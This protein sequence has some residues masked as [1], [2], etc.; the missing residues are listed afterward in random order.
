MSIN[1]KPAFAAAVAALALVGCK[2]TEN[3][4]N[5]YVASID[6]SDCYAAFEDLGNL[7][8][9]VTLPEDPEERQQMIATILS[10]Q[11]ATGEN[12]V[13][14]ASAAEAET[15]IAALGDAIIAR[16]ASSDAQQIAPETIALMG[17]ALQYADEE[18]QDRWRAEMGLQPGEEITTEAIA[19]YFMDATDRYVQERGFVAERDLN[20]V[21]CDDGGCV[22]TQNVQGEWVQVRADAAQAPSHQ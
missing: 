13:Q 17:H 9:H 8:E 7:L 2:A 4:I 19:Y 22:W 12:F 11:N 10:I 21:N 6:T 20:R 5:S 18:T 15:A 3:Q 1:V 14:C 16:Q